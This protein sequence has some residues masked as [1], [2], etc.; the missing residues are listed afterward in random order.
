ML[1][2]LQHNGIPYFG[3]GLNLREAHTPMLIER[4]GLRIALLGYDE[5]FPRSFEADTD[6]PGVAW[7]EDEQ[8]RLDIENARRQYRADLVIPFM[9]WG[10]ENAPQANARQRHLARLMIDA[11]ADAVV[12]THPH[13]TQDIEHYQGKPI[14]YSL[15]NFVFD[16]FNETANNTG[17]ILRMELDRDG[18]R[19]WRTYVAA[20]DQRGTPHPAPGGMCW[21]RGLNGPQTCQ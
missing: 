20:I 21:Q 4:R 3:G 10:W 18:V 14:I 17:W 9:H 8:V 12:G 1:G 13:V 6:K 7:S 15:G 19:L 11:G 2:L 16:G 5:F